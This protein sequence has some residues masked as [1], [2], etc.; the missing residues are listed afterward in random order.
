MMANIFVASLVF[1]IAFNLIMFVI[2]FRRGTDRL[3]DI[4]Y[5]LTFASLA[6]FATAQSGKEPLQY[7]A[8]G[9]VLVWAIRLGGFLLYRINKTGKDVRFDGMREDFLK[10]LRFWFFQGVTVWVLMIPVIALA[11]QSTVMGTLSRIG[12]VVWLAGLAIETTADFQK[13]A[14][15]QKPKNKNTWIDEGIWRYSR[16]PNY[17]GEILVWVGMYLLIAPSLSKTT[18]LISLV[19]PL[20]IIVLLLFISGIPILEKSADKK[21]GNDKAYQAYKRSTSILVLLPKR[22]QKGR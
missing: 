19:S 15:N 3:T 10:F 21:W 14:F 17:F 1:A 13:F 22:S 11:Q 4:S 2:A 20:Y 8:A 9:M 7:V 16:H 12:F 6:I 18:A 5:A